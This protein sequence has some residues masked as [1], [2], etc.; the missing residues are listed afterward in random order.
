MS[1]D[2]VLLGVINAN[3]TTWNEHQW[4]SKLQIKLHI[5]WT[6]C[7]SYNNIEITH[8]RAVT[9]CGRKL[10]SWCWRKF[11]NVSFVICLAGTTTHCRSTL[12]QVYV[13]RTTCPTSS[14][15][16]VWQAWLCIME[17]CSTVSEACFP[18]VTIKASFKHLQGVATTWEERSK[19]FKQILWLYHMLTFLFVFFKAFFIRPFYKMMLQKPITLKDMESVVS[20]TF[21]NC[22]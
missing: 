21:F 19:D 5:Q 11:W 7:I 3:Y 13:T 2:Q 18:L 10:D 4:K 22:K 17:N 14:S 8:E 16:V 1:M 6:S 12:T 20:V 15:S 9:I